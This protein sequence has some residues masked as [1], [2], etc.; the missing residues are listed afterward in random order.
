[1]SHGPLKLGEN[2]LLEKVYF[3]NAIVYNY[4]I[5]FLVRN[6]SVSFKNSA[7]IEKAPPKYELHYFI[8]EYLV[9]SI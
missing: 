5:H 3:Q 6:T 9:C 2:S 1:M 7:T 4:F 8:V